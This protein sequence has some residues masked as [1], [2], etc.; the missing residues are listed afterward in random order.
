MQ[1]GR[2]VVKPPIGVI[3]EG[4]LGQ[5]L[6]ALLAVAALNGLVAKGEARSVALCISRTSIKTAQLADV[7]AGFYSARPVGGFSTIGMP[8]G[9]L[10]A[11]D[12]PPLA[13]ILAK[14]D[15]QGASP[16]ASNIARLLDTADN[17]VLMRNQLLAQHDGNGVIV[18][19]GPCTGL[20]RLMALYGAMPQIAAKARALVVAAGAIGGP[21]DPS[22]RA[23]IAAA[24]KVFAGWP[25]P[26]VVVGAE[27]GDALPYPGASIEKDFAWSP[28]HPVAEAYRQS[29]SMPFDA[30][31]SAVA[32]VLHAVHPEADYFT[33][34]PP[35]T[36]T[37]QDDGRLVFAPAAEG[38]HR[39]LMADPA[40]KDKVT[41]L[42][43]SLVSAQPPAR[44]GR[45][46]GGP[47]AQLQQ[48]QPQQQQAVP[49]PPSAAPRP[50]APAAPPPAVPRPATP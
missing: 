23:D 36:F 28:A 22:I 49:R 11:S 42:F 20:A 9:A 25:T 34:S 19:A 31:A 27:V 10:P 24:R 6:D 15:A 16:Y 45:G 14:A 30:P 50:A 48:P 29:G 44:P 4:D 38:R 40:Q 18:V 39:Y 47:P 2:G 21:A 3:F 33:L 46:R 13:A 26:V 37:V 32:A 7:V 43:T 17:A 41:A 12:A 5:R 1:A 35:G 8:E